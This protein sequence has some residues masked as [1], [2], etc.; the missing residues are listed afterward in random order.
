MAFNPID[1]VSDEEIARACSVWKSDAQVAS[2][3]GIRA[4]RVARVR[5]ARE[6]TVERTRTG[7]NKA[8]AIAHDDGFA[9]SVT[10]SSRA[11][12]KALRAKH[13]ELVRG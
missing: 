1:Y 6:L 9:L 3:Y 10:L 11:L 12:L 7:V 13:P 8:A 4:E 5:A 2:Y